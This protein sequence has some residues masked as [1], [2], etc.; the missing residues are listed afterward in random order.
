VRK[1]DIKTFRVQLSKMVADNI[2]SAFGL[3]GI[4]VP[5]RM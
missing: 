4:A 5:E 3:L 2:R 1:P